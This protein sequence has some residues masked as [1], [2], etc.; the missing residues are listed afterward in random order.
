[1]ARPKESNP[2]NFNSK[3]LAS[4]KT[5]DGQG[6]A[7]KLKM[8]GKGNTI[9]SFDIPAHGRNDNSQG[10]SPDHPPLKKVANRFQSKKITFKY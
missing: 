10:Q 7:G 6:T 5:L 9:A 2:S 1:M 3:F 4:Q 8:K